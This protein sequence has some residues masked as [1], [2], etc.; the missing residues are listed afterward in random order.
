MIQ[1]G[2]PLR[3]HVIPMNDLFLHE[4]NCHCWCFPL[5][6]KDQPG[7]VVHNAADCREVVERRGGIT[8]PWT[9]I[10]EYEHAGVMV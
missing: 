5:A 10:A 7:M 8:A 2:R 6:D 9:T 1:P 4:A 3:V